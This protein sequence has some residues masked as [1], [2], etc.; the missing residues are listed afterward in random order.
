MIIF[1]S[2]DSNYFN[3][4]REDV[5]KYF[6]F[7]LAKNVYAYCVKTAVFFSFFFF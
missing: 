6:F 7:F 4:S 1:A 2:A 3:K 5:K